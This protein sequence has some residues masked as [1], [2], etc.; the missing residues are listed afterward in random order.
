MNEA[1][2]ADARPSTGSDERSDLLKQY[3]C[4]PIQFSGID[5]G[6]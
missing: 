2:Q 1:M 6:L 5:D 3:G 4:G